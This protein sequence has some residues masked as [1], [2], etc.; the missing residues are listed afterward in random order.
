MAASLFIILTLF[1]QK[2]SFELTSYYLLILGAISSLFAAGT[3]FLTWWINYALKRNVLVSRKIKLSILLFIIEIVLIFWR[4]SRVDI[5]NPVYFIL[6]ILIAPI[7]GLIGY[8]GG[9]LTFPTE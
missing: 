6:M 7:V 8:Y 1:L 9:Q 3:G 5:S 2:D 4:V